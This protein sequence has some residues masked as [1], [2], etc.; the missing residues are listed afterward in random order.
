MV[1]NVIITQ[2]NWPIQSFT[3][4]LGSALS[5]D[6]EVTIF[7]NEQSLSLSTVDTQEFQEIGISI[8]KS[9]F[10]NLKILGHRVNRFFMKVQFYLCGNY[11]PFKMLEHSFAKKKLRRI[12]KPNSMIIAVE[13]EGLIITNT[14]EKSIKTFYYSLELYLDDYSNTPMYKY[15]RS[16]EKKALERVDGL[17]IQDEEREKVFLQKNSLSSFSKTKVAHFPVS[18]LPQINK[19]S[20]T[21]YWHDKYNL[22]DDTTVILYFGLIKKDVRGLEEFINSIETL[23]G[24][25][26]F[27]IHGY[28]DKSVIEELAYKS[29][30]IPVY[31]SCDLVPEG[32]IDNLIASADV[33]MCWY[34]CECE[35]NR[36]TAFSSEKIA[37][38]LRSGKPILTNDSETYNRLFSKF[39]CGI[40]NSNAYEL[41]KCISKLTRNYSPMSKASFRAFDY[42]YNFEK[43]YASLLSKLKNS[44]GI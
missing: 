30:D 16:R 27:I 9:P 25:A 37:M 42:F 19:P 31:I 39:D 6:F 7:T 1:G 35:N 11:I 22:A 36:H 4:L 17:I 5:K 34:S 44:I 8:I 23:N 24:N 13:K 18:V 15:I 29:I 26:T 3:K 28:G 32:A 2:L 41:G 20:N 40:G 14:V 10:F 38:F 33:G 12:I 43:N 21:R